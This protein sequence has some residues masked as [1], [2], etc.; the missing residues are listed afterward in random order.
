MLDG[1]GRHV[2]VGE[3]LAFTLSDPKRAVVRLAAVVGVDDVGWLRGMKSWLMQ[4][5]PTGIRRVVRPHC[6]SQADLGVAV[7]KCNV[8]G[9]TPTAGY[10]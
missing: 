6:A 8:L 2:A 4:R 3:R 5:R 10:I 7:G 9:N 1:R